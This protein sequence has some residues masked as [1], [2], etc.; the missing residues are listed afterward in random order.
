LSVDA[1]GVI[2]VAASGC[3]SV[4]RIAPDGRITK[5][6]QL[7][8]PWSPTAVA[9]FGTDVYVLEYLHTAAEDRRAWVPRVR[10]VSADG[11]AVVIAKVER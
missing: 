6:V 8:S 3:G 4:L 9:G 2:H 1:S 7:E 11:K 10:K 5:L